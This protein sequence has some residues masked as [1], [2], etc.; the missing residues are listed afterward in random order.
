ME[1]DRDVLV[2]SGVVV[3]SQEGSGKTL[4]LGSQQCQLL[5]KWLH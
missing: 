1:E 3:A 2:P 5:K 4:E